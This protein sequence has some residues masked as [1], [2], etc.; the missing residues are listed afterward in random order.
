MEDAL[1][2]LIVL[3]WVVCITVS[4]TL[5]YTF[6][7][8][9]K[10]QHP[11]YWPYRWG[12]F[13]GCIR[14][15]WAPLTLVFPF[16]LVSYGNDVEALLGGGMVSSWAGL[17]SMVGYSMIKRRR[18]AWVV[19]TIASFSPVGWIVNSI[20]TF[21]RWGE[22]RESNLPKPPIIDSNANNSQEVAPRSGASACQAKVVFISVDGVQSGPY[23]LFQL[24]SMWQHG[25]V[26]ANTVYWDEPSMSWFALSTLLEQSRI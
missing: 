9:L 16:V 1:I 12:Y 2:G 17:Q 5:S 10:N 6:N 7:N 20:Y 22:F 25:A 11:T 23:T 21:N 18:W 4:Y 3:Y 19:G 14:L 26:P 24:Q 15:S 13:N 8:T